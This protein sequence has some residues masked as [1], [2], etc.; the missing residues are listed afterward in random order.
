MLALRA[1]LALSLVTL[2]AP[3]GCASADD[4]ESDNGDDEVATSADELSTACTKTRAQILASASG[5]RLRA[6][7]RGFTWYD[8]NVS[9]SQSRYY[10]G[11]RTDCSGFVSMC[12]ELGTSYTTASF[13]AGEAQSELLGS[14]DALAP[15]DA[16]V[17][18][19]NG[20]GHI[21]LFL[22]WNNTAHS[23]ACVI[24]QSSTALD[25]EFGTRT[26]SSLHASGY[27]PVRAD[28]F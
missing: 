21:V 5:G 11:Y 2:L 25:M 12:W 7:E 4:G 20:S 24:E 14:Y 18:R 6:I 27:H 16:L 26:T 13:A 9:Y 23:S 17:R 28:K 3:L 19:Q 15:G 22:G 10:K 1:V 8:A